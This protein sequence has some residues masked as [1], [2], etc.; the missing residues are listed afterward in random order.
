MG[1]QTAVTLDGNDGLKTNDQLDNSESVWQETFAEDFQIVQDYSSQSVDDTV[2]EYFGNLEIENLEQDVETLETGDLSDNLVIQ[3]K[4]SEILHRIKVEAGG[5]EIDSTILLPDNYDPSKEYPVVL[6]LHSYPG[7]GDGMGELIQAERLREQGVIVLLPS[8]ESG[9][10]ESN[11]VD[12]ISYFNNPF[13][14]GHDDI[15]A[16]K[17]TLNVVEELYGVDNSDVNIVAHGQGVPVAI[18]MSRQLD[19]K[20]A[21]SINRL[22]MT[23]GSM[24]DSGEKY[25]DLR[26][27]DL[28][29]YEPEKDWIQ[30]IGNF[31]AG[32]DD[33]EEFIR[34][35]IKSKPCQGSG[36]SWDGNL[37][38]NE[39]KCLDHSTMMTIFEKD[40]EMAYP[41]QPERFDGI[42]GAGSTSQFD[43][44]EMVIDM[45]NAER[46]S[47][48]F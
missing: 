42:F 26:G 17:E 38:I 22:F 23:A 16:I 36:P 9:M 37:E 7:D 25:V 27:T 35:F 40:G 31:V 5:R 45:I 48:S 41:G 24:T 12:G 13:D 20:E 19:Q 29:H 30:D 14:E 8:A 15:E 32:T 44:T 6:G 46:V 10:W 43:M 28:I 33:S 39:Y 11:K 3:E 21:G 47:R 18:E 2:S 1:E 34:N 4:E